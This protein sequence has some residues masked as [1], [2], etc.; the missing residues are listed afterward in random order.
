M[1]VSYNSVKEA[2]RDYRVIRD[3]LAARRHEY[4]S[5][6]KSLKASME[7]ISMF[8]RDK[9]DD[10]DV[11]SFKTDEGTAYRVTK[12]R[13]SVGDWQE[14]SAWVLEND[15]LQCLEKRP[16]KLAVQEVLEETGE[17]PP[18]LTVFS[19]VDMQIRK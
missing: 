4:Q 19:E 14:F 11:D 6:E 15:M 12:T 3:D 18:G 7:E 9:A 1:S 2:I 8:L 13:Y 10:L 17:L 5:V 16:A